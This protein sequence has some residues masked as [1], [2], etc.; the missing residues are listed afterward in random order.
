MKSTTKR[1]VSSAALAVTLGVA[2]VG[3]AGCP[4]DAD[5]AN[6]NLDTAADSFQVNRRVVF[7]NAILDKVI[8]EVEGF[9]SVD[10]GDGNRMTVTCKVGEGPNEKFKRNALG[11]SDNVLWW[12]EQLEDIGV[13]KDHYKFVVKPSTLIPDV[14]VN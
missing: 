7:Y 14:D 2:G 3:L 10:P 8:L 11:T 5:V 6:K 13:S 4:K 12:Y 9:C 1:L